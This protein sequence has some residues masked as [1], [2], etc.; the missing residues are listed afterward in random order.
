MFG[1][2]LREAFII[3]GL[4]AYAYGLTIAYESGFIGYFG[5]P[6]HL[7]SI[8]TTSLLVG[9]I[10]VAFLLFITLPYIVGFLSENSKRHKIGRS[11]H[12][13]AAYVILIWL[14]SCDGFYDGTIPTVFILFS[15]ALVA[16]VFVYE[17]TLSYS[18]DEPEKVE[19]SVLTAFH[20]I[21]FFCMVVLA[22]LGAY[23]GGY[24]RATNT[25]YYATL[26]GNSENEVV[27]RMYGNK[28]IYAEYDTTTGEVSQDFGV[29]MMSAERVDMSYSK[30]GP[31]KPMNTE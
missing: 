22:L 24:A 16:S 12:L 8:S 2:V 30:V 25:E 4:T 15:V 21:P 3:F 10:G 28:L 5:L 29:L 18:E 6:Y 1:R 20:T 19:K 7:I 14:I 26:R 31:L 17:L 13:V 9:S 27:L 23:M 11:V